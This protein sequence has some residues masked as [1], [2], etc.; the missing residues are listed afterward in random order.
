MTCIC[1]QIRVMGKGTPLVYRSSEDSGPPHPIGAW[2]GRAHALAQITP[3][4]PPRFAG[5]AFLCR[6]LLD[7]DGRLCFSEGSASFGGWHLARHC[8]GPGTSWESF[9]GRG[10]WP[11]VN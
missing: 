3:P 8:L 5:S 6:W 1:A 4:P 9:R 11:P 7:C 2:E 10:Q